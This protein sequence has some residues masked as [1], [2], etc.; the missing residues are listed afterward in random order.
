GQILLEGQ[1]LPKRVED[2]NPAQLRAVQIVFQMADVALN[3]ARTVGAILSR[4]LTVYQE[5]RGDAARRRVA[6][7]LDM[8]RLSPELLS[9][10]PD[11]LSGGQK[12]RVN[13]ARALAAEPSVILCDEVT[14]ALDT[15]VGAAVLELLAE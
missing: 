14:S 1:P 15:V 12:Q 2:R 9:R 10:Y 13:L 7:L 11:E 4:P 8:V 5:L 6:S 3:P